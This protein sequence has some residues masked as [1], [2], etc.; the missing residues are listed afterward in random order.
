MVGGRWPHAFP[1]SSGTVAQMLA[2]IAAAH[3][4]ADISSPTDALL[5]K[6]I[7]KGYRREHG[8]A[9]NKKDAATVDVILALL[10]GFVITANRPGKT[11][12]S[13]MNQTGHRSVQALREYFHREDAIEDNAARNLI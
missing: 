11:E 6:E 4:A 1:A 5:A 2:A 10:A 8:T 7:V 13:I 3:R 12:R 9:R